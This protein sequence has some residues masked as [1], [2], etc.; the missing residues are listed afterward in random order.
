MASA[1]PCYIQYGVIPAS[2]AAENTFNVKMSL[3]DEIKRRFAVSVLSPP[4]Q[5]L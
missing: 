1:W 2:A 3:D 5:R 4:G